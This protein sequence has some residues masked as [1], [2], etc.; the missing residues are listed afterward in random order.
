MFQRLFRGNSLAL[1]INKIIIGLIRKWWE[2]IASKSLNFMLNW[3]AFHCRNGS[4]WNETDHKSRL[5]FSPTNPHRMEMRSESSRK[6]SPASYHRRRKRHRRHRL[7]WVHTFYFVDFINSFL[8]I[9]EANR[10]AG[11]AAGDFFRADA[12]LRFTRWHIDQN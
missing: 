11:F 5:K 9:L 2:I 1:V 10:E 12:R 4:S 3:L 6:K 7:M 8:V